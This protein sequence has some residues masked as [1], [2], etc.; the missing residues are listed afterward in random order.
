MANTQPNESLRNRKLKLRLNLN[1]RILVVGSAKVNR[2]RK[3]FNRSGGPAR[4][5][6]DYSDRTKF[7]RRLIDDATDVEFQPTARQ[8]ILR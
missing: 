1:N 4:A 5:G 2:S 3:I 7:A 6:S 8:K